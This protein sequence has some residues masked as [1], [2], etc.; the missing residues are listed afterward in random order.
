M[1]QSSRGVQRHLISWCCADCSCLPVDRCLFSG[2]L[3]GSFLLRP[4]AVRPSVVRPSLLRSSVL[5]PSLLRSLALGS[6]WVPTSAS[7]ASA[8]WRGWA[9]DLSCAT[10]GLR[11]R[12]P[13]VRPSKKSGGA[14]RAD[15]Q[16]RG[17][18]GF[19]AGA[20]SPLDALGGTL[21]PA[22]NSVHRRAPHG[23]R[24]AAV[25]S[26]HD[27]PSGPDYGPLRRRHR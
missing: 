2:R 15:G 14:D 22:D 3:G 16:R 13:T 9:P 27:S 8:G 21:Y 20:E 4:F 26:P 10:T 12:R 23:A 17:G 19:G 11:R 6:R 7:P 25:A 24:T 1:W 18:R 5:R